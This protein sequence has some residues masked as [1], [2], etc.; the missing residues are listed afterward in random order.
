M[1]WLL[2]T[3]ESDTRPRAYGVPPYAEF[4]PHHGMALGDG[5]AEESPASNSILTDP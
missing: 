4:E 1:G 5:S 2:T 3:L